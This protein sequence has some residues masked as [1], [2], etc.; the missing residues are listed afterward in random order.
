MSEDFQSKATDLMKKVLTVGVGT[1]FLTEDALRSLVSEFKLPKELLTG[2]L[3]SAGKTK[4]EFLQN[5]SNEILNRFKDSV[6]PK[7][8]MEEF[9][10]KHDMDLRIQV[11]FKPRPKD[12]EKSG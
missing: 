12:S 4:N 8:L 3:D 6:D 1:V 10:L 7:A 5:L 2:I 9:L 11:S